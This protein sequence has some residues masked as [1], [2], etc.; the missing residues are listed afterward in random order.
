MLVNRSGAA[1]HTAFRRLRL[2]HD[3]LRSTGRA[4]F[5]HHS[6]FNN[7]IQSSFARS[8]ISNFSSGISCSGFCSSSIKLYSTCSISNSIVAGDAA[9]T[10]TTGTENG[11]ADEEAGN[12]VPMQYGAI[13]EEYAAIELALDSV[14]KIFT[15]ASSPSYFLPW[16]N[17]S[18]R[19]T[20]GSGCISLYPIFFFRIDWF[21]I[22]D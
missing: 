5:S 13:P 3:P 19:E 8:V 17:K 20:M 4:V 14:V 7:P 9:A 15:V 6:P 22:I 16:Q 2:T 1:A 18:Q 12:Y 21:N 10:P 11:E